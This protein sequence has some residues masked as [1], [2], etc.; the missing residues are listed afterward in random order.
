M[1]PFN[2]V[3]DS[4]ELIDPNPNIHELFILFDQQFFWT[5][6]STNA[7]IVEWS[8]R[9]TRYFFRLFLKLQLYMSCQTPLEFIFSCA[10]ICQFNPKTHHCSIRLSEPLLKLR[11]RR[12]LIDTLLVRLLFY[13]GFQKLFLNYIARN[14]SRIYFPDWWCTDFRQRWFV[15]NIFFLIN[16]S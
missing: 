16:L 6:L 13:Y 12:D 4:Y 11:K 3:D 2:L 9:M 8:K 10:G 1:N 14:D 5:A 7:C 15:R